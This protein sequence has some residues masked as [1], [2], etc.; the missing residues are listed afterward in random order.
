MK[1]SRPPNKLKQILPPISRERAAE[2]AHER[3]AGG[4]EQLSLED[5]GVKEEVA[6][7]VARRGIRRTLE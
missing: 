5:A 2:I 3:A 1:P 4:T 6:A 7:V